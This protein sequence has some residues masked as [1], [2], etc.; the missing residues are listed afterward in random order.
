MKTKLSQRGGWK[1][2]KITMD[3][4]GGYKYKEEEWNKE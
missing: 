3:E 2:K 1:R 4:P